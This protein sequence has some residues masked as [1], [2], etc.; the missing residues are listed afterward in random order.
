MAGRPYPD[1]ESLLD[2]GSAAAD[3]LSD[4][5]LASAISRHPRIGER[6]APV[7]R[8]GR[9]LA[10]RAGRGGPS[11]RRGAASRGGTRR[12]RQ[13]FGRVF[14]IRAA[15]RSSAEILAELD[16][17]L[18]NDDA[19][20]RAETVARAP[21]HRRAP[22]R[23]GGRM[24]HVSTH[25][26]DTA[27]G[28][29]GGRASRSRLEGGGRRARHRR[30]TDA[31]RPDHRPGTRPTRAGDVPA[32]LRHRPVRRG[33]GHDGFFPEVV[34]AFAVRRRRPPARAAAAQSRSAT[35]PTGG[36]DDGRSCWAPTTTA[37]PRPRLVRVV[38]DD[39]R[40]VVRDLNV[41]T[42]AGRRLRRGAPRR[43]PGRTCCRPTRQKNTVFAFA[44]RYGI[45]ADRGLRLAA[46]PALRRRRR[47]R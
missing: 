41:S 25:V 18:G 34:V 16:R 27:T 32:A 19:T 22:T 21:R 17:R 20:E 11:D 12:T 33:D 31:R 8:R 23:A 42:V 5:E 13:R 30:S 15:G 39:R 2:R 47:R 36:A 1:R 6:P 10:R 43:R 45:D 44:E 35:R 46:R 28:R 26:L 29:P 40:H 38:R 4:D 3:H 14:L 24:S 7:R 9:A 37:R